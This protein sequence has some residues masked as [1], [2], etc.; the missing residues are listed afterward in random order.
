ME[1][2]KSFSNIPRFYFHFMYLYLHYTFGSI[3]P[4][5]KLKS[6]HKFALN[7][8][9]H[10]ACEQTGYFKLQIYIFYFF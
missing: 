6:N 9:T 8:L 4:Y 2:N 7:L 10:L 3:Q 1:Q 5:L